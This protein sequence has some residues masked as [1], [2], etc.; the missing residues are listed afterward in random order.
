ML[1]TAPPQS[2]SL[3]TQWKVEMAF[4]INNTVQ[5]PFK[6]ILAGVPASWTEA[7][8]SVCVWLPGLGHGITELWVAGRK[9]Q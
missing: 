4:R 9:P 5:V 2:V 7:G 3:I 8:K 1:C 6:F